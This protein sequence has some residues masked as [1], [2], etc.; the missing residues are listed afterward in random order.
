MLRSRIEA[1]ISLPHSENRLD[2]QRLFAEVKS[3]EGNPRARDEP[4]SHGENPA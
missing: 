1:R 2:A 3:N 4:S